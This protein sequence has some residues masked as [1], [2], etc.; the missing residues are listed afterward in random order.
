MSVGES[1]FLA[2]S[3]GV[4]L[5]GGLLAHKTLRPTPRVQVY[6]KVLEGFPKTAALFLFLIVLVWPV[7]VPILYYQGYR[8]EKK[9]EEGK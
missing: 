6:L 7:S 5:V 4:F 2:W 1:V 9:E 3:M 8:D